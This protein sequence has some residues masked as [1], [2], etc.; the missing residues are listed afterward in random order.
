MKY[1][2]FATLHIMRFRDILASKYREI[3]GWHFFRHHFWSNGITL[4]EDGEEAAEE[5]QTPRAS[6]KPS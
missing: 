2:V 1:W 6:N 5:N 3:I 4:R